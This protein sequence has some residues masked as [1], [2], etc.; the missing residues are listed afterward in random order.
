MT[1]TRSLLS[2][3]YARMVITT[4]I[5]LMAFAVLVA[6]YVLSSQ[7][8]DM[9]DFQY[10][11]GELAIQQI[12]NHSTD[13]L[14]EYDSGKL[15]KEAKHLFNI[16]GV[17]GIILH[18]SA[19]D[20]TLT[21]GRINAQ[22]IPSISNFKSGLPRKVD[23]QQY[24]FRHIRAPQDLNSPLRS[25]TKIGWAMV[26]IDSQFLMGRQEEKVINTVLVIIFSLFVAA[27]LSI[28]FTRTISMPIELSL[29]HI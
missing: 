17:D 25:E 2:G 20:K 10:L 28:R 14:I 29:I 24:F 12:V 13:A 8:Q 15:N 26:A 22:K 1:E 4:L 6:Y 3:I 11:M 5:P 18:N 16:A 21:L 23:G 9:E 19:M 27:W 7:S